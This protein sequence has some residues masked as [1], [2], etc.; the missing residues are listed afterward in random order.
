V[1]LAAAVG[2]WLGV[3]GLHAPRLNATV[4]GLGGPSAVGQHRR[5]PDGLGV[6]R[7]GG[8]REEEH[9]TPLG[10]RK[11]PA[12]AGGVTRTGDESS[13]AGETEHNARLTE[14][15]TPATAARTMRNGNGRPAAAPG[16]DASR[17]PGASTVAGAQAAGPLLSAMSYASR[18]H[19]LYPHMTLAA[20]DQILTGFRIN[21]RTADAANE[22]VT[23]TGPDRTT[24]SATFSR[25]D[26]LYFVE[27]RLGD[28]GA[29]GETNGGDDGFILTDAHGHILGR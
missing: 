9:T 13:G 7:P 19:E 4:S 8:I 3:A 10:G 16:S 12:T 28:D 25:A 1:L 24:Q 15:D 22:V 18:A 21:L 6:S 14:R 27:T 2:V 11:A 29:D 26:R 23:V 20:D 17:G 5:A